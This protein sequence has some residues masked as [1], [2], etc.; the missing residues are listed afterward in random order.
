MRTCPH[1]LTETQQEVCPSDGFATISS[2]SYVAPRHALKPGHTINNRYKV[3]DKIGAGGF[4]SVYKGL[5]LAMDQTVAIKVLRMEDGPDA[6][7]QLRRFHREAR[8]ASCLQHPNTIRVFDFG[9][10]EQGFLY[11]V[12]EYI[13]GE[14][15]L[16]AIKNAGSLS[17][18]RCARIAQQVLFSLSEAHQKDIVHR[19]IKP[20]NIM[21]STHAGVPDH[22]KVLDF[23][24]AK[25]ISS[26]SGQSSLTTKGMLFGS[27]TYMSP[28]QIRGAGVDQ[29][30]DLYA[31][32]AVMYHMLAGRPPFVAETPMSILFKHV[33][34]PVP[35]LPETAGGFPIP[36]RLRN[37]VMRLLAKDPDERPPNA[38]ATLGALSIIATNQ[39]L[40]AVSDTAVTPV[41]DKG[42]AQETLPYS[43]TAGVTRARVIGGHDEPSEGKAGLWIALGMVCLLAVGGGL[44]WKFGGALGDEDP[45]AEPEVAAK[46]SNANASEDAVPPPT[47]E[48]SEVPGTD[49]SEPATPPAGPVVERVLWPAALAERSQPRRVQ[50]SDAPVAE[51]TVEPVVE[52]VVVKKDEPKTPAPVITVALSASQPA[53]VILP[54]GQSVAVAERAVLQKLPRTKKKLRFVFTPKSK[55]YH[56]RTVVVSGDSDQAV[57]A[58]FKRK[59]R[60]PGG[61]QPT[62][63]TGGFGPI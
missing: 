53:K 47:T 28:E 3:R 41:S 36:P 43:E 57:H 11:M 24:I 25:V 38:D 9:Q 61:T 54:D 35:P 37:L 33:H 4:G 20:E 62:Q 22:V 19:D 44:A 50:L 15:L 12:M 59:R 45:P 46:T 23:G 63:P 18:Q 34:E 52:P 14:S 56:P 26:D 55:R 17:G 8:S 49:A 29:R 51:P 48:S 30:S 5:N 42:G 13:S 1:C 27:P 21:L 58:R 7:Q 2:A 40:A 32:G 31:V 6:P 60:P 16:R 39:E 10:S